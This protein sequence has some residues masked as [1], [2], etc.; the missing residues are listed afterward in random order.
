MGNLSDP[1]P[2]A[3]L[4][5]LDLPKGHGEK[6]G[7]LVVGVDVAGLDAPLIQAAPDEVVLNA[8]MLAALM[9]DGVLRQGQGGLAIHPELHCFCVSAQEI[10]QQPSQSESLSRSGSGSDV[11]RLA[12]GQIH[13]LLLDQLPAN[14]T[15]AKEEQ[16]AAGA[17]ACVD[18]VGEV[19]V[20]VPDE[21][22]RT[23]TR[24]VVQAVVEGV[25]DV[26]DDPLDGLFVLHRQP[27]H[28]PTDVA[29][30]ER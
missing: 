7:K 28:E 6:V 15:L 26:A 5:E 4:M 24:R 29:N 27:L 21:V 11:L 1:N 22:L 8:D 17:L 3:K 19:A 20:A 23:G 9:E 25:R 10:A 2:S 13:H 18:V 30:G 16:R 12:T 14:Q